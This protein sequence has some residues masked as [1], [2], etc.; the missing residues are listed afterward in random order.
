M[1]ARE[2]MSTDVHA[3]WQI[4]GVPVLMYHGIREE[5][6][7]PAP[8]DKYCL[9]RRS[10]AAQVEECSR[11]A[12][13]IVSLRNRWNAPTLDG[14]VVFTFDDG[15]ASDYEIAFPILRGH[16]CCADFF[17]TSSTVGK[18]GYVGWEQLKEMDQA[19]M[20]IQ[21]HGSQHTPLTLLNSSVLRDQ[22]LS[23]KMEIEDRLGKKVE[24]LAAPFGFLNSRVLNAALDLGFV[25]VCD[26][27]SWPARIGSKVIHRVAVERNTSDK[28]FQALLRRSAAPL[29]MRGLKRKLLHVPKQVLLRLAPRMLGL[30]TE[31]HS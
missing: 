26:S 5:A 17:V 21:S 19:G 24:F 25:A 6:A 28:Q 18:A 4:P 15:L 23:G 12:L 14:S 30:P 10:F 29:V 13:S 7:Q 31:V 16:G 1:E 11:L 20:S 2:L 8:R 3:A 9:E 27:V 22:L